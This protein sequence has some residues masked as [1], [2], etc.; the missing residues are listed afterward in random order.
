MNL[1]NESKSKSKDDLIGEM[2]ELRRS[3]GALKKSFNELEK[4]EAKLQRRLTEREKELQLVYSIS[5]LMENGKNTFAE[6]FQSIVNLIPPGWQYPEITCAR[7]VLDGREYQSEGFKISQWKQSENILIENDVVGA[8]EVYY[9]EKKPDEF[10]G[11]FLKEEQNLLKVIA[12][13][14]GRTIDLKKL[15]DKY[16]EGQELNHGLINTIPFGMHIVSKSGEILFANEKMQHQF[17]ADIVGKKC[18]LSYRSDKNQ[19]P[20]CPLSYDIKP[21]ITKVLEVDGI[22]EHR[23]FEVSYTGLIYKDQEALLEIFQDITHRKKVEKDLTESNQKL[24]RILDNLEDAFFQGDLDGNCTYLNPAAL[25]MFGYDN[26]SEILG[27]SLTNLYNDAL[28]RQKVMEEIK[29]HGKIT[30]LICKGKRKDSS[31]FW[32][33]MNAQFIKDENGDITGTEGL[34]R[35][36]SERKLNELVLEEKQH[37]LISATKIAGLGYFIVVGR[38]AYI[39]TINERAHQI[40]GLDKYNSEGMTPLTFWLNNIHPDDRDEVLT[41][42]NEVEKGL[43]DTVSIVYRYMHPGNGTIWISHN[44]EVLQRDNEGNNVKIFGVI[45]D[46]TEIKERE[47][48]LNKA[49]EKSLENEIRFKAIT[50]QAMDGIT[51]TDMDGR[52][53]FIN[54]AFSNIIGYSEQELKQMTIYDLV[55]S[56]NKDRTIFR[57]VK[58]LQQH[59]ARGKVVCR[60]GSAKYV[61]INGK[62]I[63]INDNK[64]IL[65]IIR[66]V[67]DIVKKEDELIAAKQRAEDNETQ[68]K[69]SQAMAKLGSW[70]LDI[71]TGIFTFTDNFYSIFKTSAEEMGGYKMTINEYASRFVHPDDCHMVEKEVM[72]AIKTDDPDFAKYLE[73][74]IRYIDGSTGYIGV[75]FFIKKDN[76]GKTIKTYGVNQDITDRKIAEQ[77]LQES[78]E[79][80]EESEKRF[81]IIAEQSTEGITVADLKGNYVYVNNTFCQ[82]S[83]YTKEELLKMTVFD[84]GSGNVGQDDDVYYREENVSGKKRYHVLRKKDGTDYYTEITG[85]YIEIDKQ[86]LILGSIRDVSEIV[87]YQND[88]IAAKEKAEE[89][90]KLKSAFLMN[91]SHEIRTPMN[92]IL[93]FIDLLAQPELS[94]AEKSGFIDIVNKSGKRLL[95]TINDIVEISKIEV[96]DVH[97][98]YEVVDVSEILQFQYNF[99]KMQAMEKGVG[100]RI[101]EQITGDVAIIETDKHKLD[102]ILMNLIKNAIKFTPEGL[103]E[104]GNYIEDDKLF[105]YVSDSGR[106]IP[107]D[108]VEVIFDRFVQAELGNTRGYEGSGIGLSIVKAYIEAFKGK[109]EVKSEVGKGSTFL[110]SIPYVNA[111]A[112]LQPD[113]YLETKT[114]QSTVL[115]AEDDEV[116]YYYLENVLSAEFDLLHAF[117]GEQAVQL[118]SERPDVS[119]VL[120]DIK[121]PGEIDGL[122]AT[123]KIRQMNQQVPI[124]AQSA[125]VQ[126]AD[127]N[128]AFNAGCNDYLTKPYNS[129]QLISMVKKHCRM[130]HK[131]VGNPVI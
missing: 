109:I 95:N 80:A 56:A 60:D 106:G 105:F 125:F 4:K 16:V 33:S 19:C 39:E 102:G 87:K 64:F 3:Y 128:K 130:E 34:V 73:H 108:K 118:F 57:K 35:D 96:G 20:Q 81:R 22:L 84:M 24:K 23:T 90:D 55:P 65:G 28:D 58:E 110:F 7:V 66:D 79:K 74:K 67:S 47:A 11:P 54:Q 122:E 9:T 94:D 44:A 41:L 13:H 124:I 63:G 119:L 75:R 112:V 62:I 48:E 71:E 2:D 8:V 83:G 113:N 30:D 40:L 98:N 18:W 101:R 85:T 21:G 88:L 111:G 43:R 10:T 42:I 92:G 1:P 86:K 53:V 127:K 97:L 126:E 107:E 78:K 129:G 15:G 76:S 50:E 69:E 120:M 89:S 70:E 52:F 93:G 103:I 17:G 121:M 26:E 72:E 77:K 25:R 123:Q 117:D 14:I 12:E 46:I 115:I 31:T 99:F 37:Q 49:R 38:D 91:V 5:A 61:D 32:V 51:L 59:S 27:Q 45:Q 131:T 82:M 29:K 68:L 36:I 116:S 6:T 104:I 114:Q 100:L